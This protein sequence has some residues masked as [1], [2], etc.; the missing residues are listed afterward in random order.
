MSDGE[1]KVLG[2]PLLYFCLRDCDLI[3]ATVL[4]E[5]LKFKS[6]E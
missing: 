5:R 2:C 6:S 4:S 3:A 1:M